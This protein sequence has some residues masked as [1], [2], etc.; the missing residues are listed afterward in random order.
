MKH[1]DTLSGIFRPIESSG[2]Q[3]TR[4]VLFDNSHLYCS[5]KETTSI[6]LAH[7]HYEPFAG[8]SRIALS[9]T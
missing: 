5:D 3:R 2:A 6:V 9:I 4:F 1:F 7:R 8:C